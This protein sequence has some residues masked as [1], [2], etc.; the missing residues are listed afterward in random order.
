MS[1]TERPRGILSPAD[2]RYLLGETDYSSDQSERDAR[3]RIRNRLYNGVLDL[4]LALHYLESRDFEMVLEKLEEDDIEGAIAFF[5]YIEAAREVD[6]KREEMLETLGRPHHPATESDSN[7]E[8]DGG[9]DLSAFGVDCPEATER[10]QE[11]IS[12]DYKFTRPQ[13]RGLTNDGDRCSNPVVRGGDEDF[14]P[15]HADSDC[16]TI[17]DQLATDGGVDSSGTVHA[18]VDVPAGGRDV[19]KEVI[20]YRVGPPVNY[21]FFRTLR[22]E[23]LVLWGDHMQ[24][25]WL[26]ELST[27]CHGLEQEYSEMAMYDAAREAD[28]MEG[29]FLRGDGVIE[30]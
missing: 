13:C 1:G 30:A 20:E 5:E 14:C 18:V 26:K 8:T 2:R 16:E 19:A 7:L 23:K 12:E 15:R 3:Y 29:E 22:G 6:Q 9:Q 27:A 25:R 28:R 21:A 17:D 24:E 4:N 10:P 11:D